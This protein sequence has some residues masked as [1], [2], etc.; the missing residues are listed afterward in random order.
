[1]ACRSSGKDSVQVRGGDRLECLHLVREASKNTAICQF[2]CT[3]KRYTQD[4]IYLVVECIN[5]FLSLNYDV[6]L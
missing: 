5:G 2:F 6:Y 1:M 3:Y 4:A